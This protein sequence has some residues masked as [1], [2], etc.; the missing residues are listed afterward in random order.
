M[1]SAD[2]PIQ[3]DLMSID[4]VG[5]RISFKAD[6][7]SRPRF[8]SNVLAMGMEFANFEELPLVIP[9]IEL[10]RIL[11]QRSVLVQ[12]IFQRFQEQ[13]VGIAINVFRNYGVVGS[14]SK[15]R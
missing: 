4:E 9:G 8:S 1:A 3:L 7:G 12:H 11:V 15:A 6:V 2:P 10:E 13:T 5:L 14:M